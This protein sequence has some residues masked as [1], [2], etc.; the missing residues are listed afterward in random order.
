VLLDKELKEDGT[1]KYL[2]M[3]K[4]QDKDGTLAK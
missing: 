4:M 3:G 2:Y 1:W